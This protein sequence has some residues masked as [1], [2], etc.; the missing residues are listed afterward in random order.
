MVIDQDPHQFC[1]GDGGMRVVQLEYIFFGKLAEILAMALNP[2]PNDILKA[3]AG[4][5]VLLAQPQ[6]LAIFAGV[7]GIEHHRDIFGQILGPHRLGIVSGV[8]FTQ[9]ELIG[10]R[11]FPEP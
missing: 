3:G 8:E 10:R 4:E 7:I 5:E 11:S 6:L 2:G 1:N 9:A